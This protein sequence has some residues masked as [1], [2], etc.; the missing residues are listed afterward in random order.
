MC[1]FSPENNNNEPTDNRESGR[2]AVMPATPSLDSVGLDAATT[3]VLMID[4]QKDYQGVHNFAVFRRNVQKCRRWA[5][6]HPAMHVCHVFEV[7]N[8]N[9]HWLPFWEELQGR[10]RPRDAGTPFAFSRPRAG[11]AVFL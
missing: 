10:P 11:E 5:R 7:D 1:F 4:I 6:R 3:A 8:D 9:S 2:H